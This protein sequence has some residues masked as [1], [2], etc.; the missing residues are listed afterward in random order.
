MPPLQ[1][2]SRRKPKPEPVMA[3]SSEPVQDQASK[4]GN[5]SDPLPLEFHDFYLPIAHRKGTRK[6]T[7]HPIAN[8]ISFANLSPA[9]RAFLTELNAIKI[10]KLLKK[11]LEMGSEKKLSLRK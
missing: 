2:S 7:Q 9:H 3:Q 1:V 10:P 8:F 4:A 6:C 5:K 11:H